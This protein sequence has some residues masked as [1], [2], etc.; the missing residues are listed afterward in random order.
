MSLL[1]TTFD[2]EQFTQQL[3]NELNNGLP[4]FD[5]QKIMSPSIR[6]HALKKSDPSIAR[7]SSV[8]LLF[9]PKD[10]QLYLPFIKRT[11][12]NTS[13]SGQ[14]SLP[15]GKYEESDSNRTVTAIRETNE[16]LGVDCKK[17]KILG[18]LTELYIPISNFMVLP[19]L[20]YCKQR[21]EFKIS[22][23][24]VEEVIEMPVQQ[25]LS[26]ENISEF[27]F[28]KNDLT[29]NAPYFDAKGH[30]VW[31]ATAMIL[32]ELR[33]IFLRAGLIR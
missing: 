29:I 11:S 18:F 8:L 12:G 16:E 4:G 21:P 17:I 31:G 15:G 23:F 30:K 19:V 7:D 28:T 5:A 26:K 24:E 6:E 25:L 9:Y 14:I 2:L 33:E 3:N 27:S 22:P 1:D 13:H 10:G 32:S 20:G